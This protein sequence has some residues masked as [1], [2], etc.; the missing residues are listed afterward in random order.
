MAHVGSLYRALE[1]V[2]RNAVK[3]TAEGSAVEIQVEYLAHTQQ[4]RIVISDRGPGV[5]DADL[6]AIFE[7]F[8][9]SANG[10]AAAGFGLGLAIARRAI[11]ANGGH[12][13]ARNRTGGGLCMEI[14]LPC[15]AL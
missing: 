11:E 8:Y 2:I 14:L 10:Q 4:A 5:P 15:E 1:N 9:R 13:Q 6:S 7:P 12:I 3:Y